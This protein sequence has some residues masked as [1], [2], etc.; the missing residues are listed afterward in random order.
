MIDK[1]IDKDDYV[2]YL[3]GIKSLKNHI[4]LSGYNTDEATWKAC[5]VLYLSSC[6]LT[7][8]EFHKIENPE[9]YIEQKL[10]V[11]EYK[12]LSYVRK[13]NAESYAYL[14]EATRNLSK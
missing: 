7:G 12:K 9:D 14:V 13:Q 10:E 11:E 4:L 8:K 6:L 2:E 3:K 1:K 5:K